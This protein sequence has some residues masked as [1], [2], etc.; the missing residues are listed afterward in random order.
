[1][2]TPSDLHGQPPLGPDGP[3]TSNMPMHIG[4]VR[5]NSVTEINKPTGGFLEPGTLYVKVESG[6]FRIRSGPD[7]TA[8]D[9][10]APA[11]TTDST[12]EGFLITASDGIIAFTAPNVFVAAGDGASAAMSYWW[13]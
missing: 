12:D 7:N 5:G 9:G 10:A 4:H 2:P 8:F 3:V 6:N 1:M 13:A 11:A